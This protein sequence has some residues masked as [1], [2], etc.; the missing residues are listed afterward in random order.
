MRI[1]A[2]CRVL[3][4]KEA[5]CIGASGIG[6]IHQGKIRIETFR[7]NLIVSDIFYEIVHSTLQEY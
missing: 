6:K 1:H 4:L 7:G 2:C 3:L 5:T